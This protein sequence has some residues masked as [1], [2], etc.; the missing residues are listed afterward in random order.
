MYF[1]IVTSYQLIKSCMFL[2]VFRDDSNPLC[3]FGYFSGRAPGEKVGSVS[4]RGY[5]PLNDSKYHLYCL[6]RLLPFPWL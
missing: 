3:L 2:V 1:H 4:V 6:L 5:P